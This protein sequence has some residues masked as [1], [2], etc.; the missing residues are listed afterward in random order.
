MSGGSNET[1]L[2]NNAWGVVIRL[3]G[4]PLPTGYFLILSLVSFHLCIP[5][6]NSL[7]GW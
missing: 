5:S 4:P 2:Y 6:G 1:K 7:S 3:H